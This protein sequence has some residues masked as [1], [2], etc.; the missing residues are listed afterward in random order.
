MNKERDKKFKNQ[1]NMEEKV[2]E[3]EVNENKSGII[4]TGR[5]IEI[6]NERNQA[7]KKI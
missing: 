4:P 3:K 1:N 2:T 6:N 7:K 5:D